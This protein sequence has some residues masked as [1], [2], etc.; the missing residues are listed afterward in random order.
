MDPVS[1]LQQQTPTTPQRTTGL[2]EEKTI[3]TMRR[4]TRI[5]TR[6]TTTDL[7]MT[8][9]GTTASGMTDSVTV[10]TVRATA[11]TI[12]KR[13]QM[14]NGDGKPSKIFI[15]FRIEPRIED[16]GCQINVQMKCL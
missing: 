9:L 5:T 11:L 16:F 1:A 14:M 10:E 13:I 4:M 8:D 2:A 3:T 12:S 15:L 6:L 7:V